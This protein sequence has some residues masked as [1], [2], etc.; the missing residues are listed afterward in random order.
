MARP[1]EN[2]RRTQMVLSANGPTAGSIKS[3]VAAEA[4]RSARGSAPIPAPRPIL[5]RLL[6]LV[7]RAS[8]SNLRKIGNVP[9]ETQLTRL[10]EIGAPVS[11]RSLGAKDS[12]KSL[13]LQCARHDRW[14]AQSPGKRPTPYG[15]ASTARDFAS[16]GQTILL[17]D[18][19]AAHRSDAK[20]EQ[21]ASSN[22]RTLRRTE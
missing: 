5:R 4:G 12:E 16:P 2:G 22:G 20:G 1:A 3:N 7:R 15:A 17:P 9:H 21:P 13:T 6:G 18:A 14:P 11:A 10:A 19:S 8:R